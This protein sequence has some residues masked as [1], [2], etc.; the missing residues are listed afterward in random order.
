MEAACLRIFWKRGVSATGAGNA[1]ERAACRV[2]LYRAMKIKVGAAIE[3]FKSDLHR[4]LLVFMDLAGFLSVVLM[5][6]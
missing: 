5:T 2:Y 4:F 3:C 6:R 1:F